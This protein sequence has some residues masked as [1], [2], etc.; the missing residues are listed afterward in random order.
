MGQFLLSPCQAAGFASSTLTLPVP[1]STSRRAVP[2][3]PAEDSCQPGVPRGAEFCFQPAA[4]YF[5]NESL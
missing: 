4:P 3:Q 1:C 5:M 2:P